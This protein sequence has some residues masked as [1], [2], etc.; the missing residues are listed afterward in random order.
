MVSI[1]LARQFPLMSILDH[2]YIC[3]IIEIYKQFFVLR[4]K[5]EQRCQT[6]VSFKLVCHH[7]SLCSYFPLLG[8][9]LSLKGAQR[10]ETYPE[11][12]HST[13]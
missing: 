2:N 1:E 11:L 3:W 13:G 4:W 9:P 5:I 6:I 8:S 10:S 7:T 12:R